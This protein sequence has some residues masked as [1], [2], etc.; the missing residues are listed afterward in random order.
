MQQGFST[1]YL[2]NLFS[3]EQILVDP[4]LSLDKLLTR[5]MD[6]IPSDSI[7]F[8][9]Y[10]IAR[11]RLSS[12]IFQD[13]DIHPVIESDPVL[14]SDPALPFI[15][16]DRVGTVLVLNVKAHD[17]YEARIRAIDSLKRIAGL[18]HLYTPSSHNTARIYGG[19]LVSSAQD[20]SV[21]YID[22]DNAWREHIGD[23]KKPDQ[24]VRK[25]L[26]LKTTKFKDWT[27]LENSLQYHSLA[28]QA[29]T[30]EARLLNL[31]IALESLLPRHGDSIISTVAST[32]PAIMASSYAHRL[33]LHLS[34]T[35][36]TQISFQDQTTFSLPQWMTRSKYSPRSVKPLIFI[37]IYDILYGLTDIVDGNRILS[38]LTMA[39]GNPHLIHQINSLWMNEFKDRD[40]FQKRLVAH[41]NSVDGQIRRIYR[42]RNYVMHNGHSCSGLRYL[43]KNL[44]S[45]YH[46]V[47]N[48]LLYDIRA[49]N[50]D[51]IESALIY[52]THSYGHLLTSLP[53][54]ELQISSASV[55]F[56]SFDPEWIKEYPLLWQTP[57]PLTLPK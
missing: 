49:H 19:V 35:I 8:T 26:S 39:N 23:S 42:A 24:S 7:G 44:H 1:S 51:S 32:I 45:Y 16:Q 17:K 29:D 6:S 25:L 13:T 53:V 12:T 50:L 37:D 40:V 55:L 15:S 22:S 31:W 38:M 56:M 28:V 57:A 18:L 43:V 46:S 20:H 47:I 2:R 14:N 10:C 34:A 9:C 52:R 4:T 21:E 5:V 30:D 41:Q 11:W 33:C 3:A 36:R 54:R 48:T 27:S